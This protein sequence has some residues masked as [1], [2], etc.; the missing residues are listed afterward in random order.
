[1][2]PSVLGALKTIDENM[3]WQSDYKKIVVDQLSSS[4]TLANVS[5]L[6]ILLVFATKIFN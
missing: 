1:V 3:K 6:L 4:A 2:E 5:P